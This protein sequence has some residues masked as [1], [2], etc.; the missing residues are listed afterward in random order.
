MFVVLV[1]QLNLASSHLDELSECFVDGV[2][3]SE[4]FSYIG[5]DL[6]NVRASAKALGVL[7]ADAALHLGEIILRT[8]IVCYCVSLLHNLCVRV[9]LPVVR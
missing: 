7:A 1:C 6:G 5:V 3:V 2:V 9:V 4:Y 8:K